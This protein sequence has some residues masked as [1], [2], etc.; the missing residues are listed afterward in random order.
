MLTTFYRVR[1]GDRVLGDGGTTKE[2]QA[3]LAN[4]S[5]GEY[6]VEV[7]TRDA[8]EDAGSPRHWGRAIKHED[9]TVHLESEQPGE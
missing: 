5:P 7:V 1:S 9:G 3:L 8:P 2:I 4:A 6:P